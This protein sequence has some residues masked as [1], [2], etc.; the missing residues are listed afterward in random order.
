MTGG[1]EGLRE[2]FE[3]IV[4]RVQSFGVYEFNL[5]KYA[6]IKEL[7]A[8]KHFQSVA[9]EICPADKSVLDPFQFN[10]I[11]QLP[12]QTVPLHL[13]APYFFG[14]SRFQFPQWV[15]VSMVFSDL[16]R[17]RF[18]DQ[19]QVVGYLHKFDASGRGG[20]FVAFTEGAKD[21]VVVPSMSFSGT[22][23]D[24]SKTVHAA[25]QYMPESPLPLINK[26]KNNKLVYVGDGKWSLESDGEKLRDYETDDIRMTIV[27]RARCFKDEKERQRF[28]AEQV[29][30][31]N[32]ERYEDML[33]LDDVLKTFADDLAKRGLVTSAE[34]ALSMKRLKLANLILDTYIRYPTNLERVL[35][36]NYCIV[37]KEFPKLKPLFRM[38]GCY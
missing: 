22:A 26:D 27:Y 7:F 25:R 6:V 31:K 15:L 14:A 13:D 28:G 2:N 8:S 33:E 24:G 10:F 38:F 35:P 34:Q 16:F 9:K 29:S 36:I 21:P 4:S 23:V 20:E 30:A 17:A 5:D 18:V 11:L 3:Q 37:T 32:L 19:V 12:G 1:L